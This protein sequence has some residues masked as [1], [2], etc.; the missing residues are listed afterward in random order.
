MTLM[1]RLKKLATLKPKDN[2]EKP[3]IN[4]NAE[5]NEIEKIKLT[6]YQSGYGES[7]N[8]NGDYK[9][10]KG[11]LENVYESFK[12]KCRKNEEEHRKLNQPYIEER[13]R[14]ENELKKRE[15]AIEIKEQELQNCNNEIQKLQD[16]IANVKSEPEKHG[17]DAKKRPRAQFFIG[18]L[19]LIPITIYLIVFYISASYSAFF[20][21]FTET[22]IS[23]AIFDAEAISKAAK[24]G[25]LEAI[26]VGT[27]PFAFMGLGYLIHMFGKEKIIGKLK[28]SLL[29][30]ITFIF[31][32]ILAFQIE[33]KIYD[34]T[35]TLMSP[36]FDLL[37]A[38]TKVEFWGIIFA[39]FV[40]YIIWGLVFDFIMKEHENV[41]KIKG[42]ITMC[43]SKLEQLVKRKDEIIN[44]QNEIKQV[45]S[46]INGKITELQ[47]KI[48]GIIIPNKKYLL[49]H[50]EYMKGWNMAISKEL[51]LPKKEK[52][53]LLSNCH[54]VETE[55]L[56]KYKLESDDSENILYLKKV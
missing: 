9:I 10:L 38:F 40:V 48:D 30:V 44:I 8:A 5:G 41:D 18:L 42:F 17:I 21:D 22:G 55:H 35:K 23:A 15:T 28:I 32:A 54:D 33:K 50:T 53:L 14:Q 6:Y 29:L 45:I 49:L 52:D 19:I 39:G 46:E 34:I 51:A 56:K 16:D 12:E 3:E 1:N 26:F 31:D 27:L 36:E 11:C 2:V 25:L 20:K 37:I 24:D 47:Q 7:K 13:T 4:E 43:K